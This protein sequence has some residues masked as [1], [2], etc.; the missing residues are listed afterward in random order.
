M[1]KFKV[2]PRIMGGLG[3]QLFIY[4][5]ARR[6]ALKSN[7]ELIIDAKSGFTHDIR[8]KRHFSLIIST[9]AVV[10]LQRLNVG[11]FL[12]CSPFP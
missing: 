8:Y 11:A 10:K 6:L 7:A 12:T 2:I 4:S 1:G 9:F 3:N 5:A